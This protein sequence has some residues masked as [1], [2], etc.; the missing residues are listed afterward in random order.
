LSVCCSALQEL[1]PLGNLE[2]A[3]A[4]GWLR[5]PAFGGKPYPT[6][7][8]RALS[9]PCFAHGFTHAHV[10]TCGPGTLRP[11]TPFPHLAAAAR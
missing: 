11:H 8:V 4:K 2:G 6:D 9:W 7:M 5:K 3:V 1:C 10:R